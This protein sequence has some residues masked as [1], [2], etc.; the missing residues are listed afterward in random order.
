MSS[1]KE[2]SRLCELESMLQGRASTTTPIVTK[3]VLL[4][5]I[6]K[7]NEC[8][9]TIRDGCDLLVTNFDI[10]TGQ[11]KRVRSRV[12]FLFLVVE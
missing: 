11:Q 9:N 10:I 2:D 12:L 3:E 5:S 6:R 8:L 1:R 4:R 7:H